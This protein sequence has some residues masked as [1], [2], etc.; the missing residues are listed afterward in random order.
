MQRIGLNK[1]TKAINYAKKLKKLGYFSSMQNEISEQELVRQ[2]VHH[3]ANFK[4]TK[5]QVDSRDHEI[6]AALNFA[7]K[8]AK[9]GRWR[10][11]KVWGQAIDLDLEKHKYLYCEENDLQLKKFQSKV[12]DYLT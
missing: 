6:D 5:L 9:E 8:A 4:I 7:Y 1:A 3:A 12:R 11:P 10:C 2:F